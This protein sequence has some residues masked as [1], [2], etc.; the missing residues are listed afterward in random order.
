MTKEERLELLK[1]IEKDIH[2]CSLEST[3]LDEAKSCAI[4]SVIEELEQEHSDKQRYVVRGI[5]N[6]KIEFIDKYS[7]RAFN[8]YIKFIKDSCRYEAQI[9]KE[10]LEQEP[11]LDKINKMKSEIADSLEFWDYSP[12]NNPLARDMLET[13]T[14]FWGNMSE[15]EG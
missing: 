13:L 10:A 14:N 7:V 3:L 2:V 12:N 6:D 4:H 15:V 11:I 1:Q 8:R 9:E 5:N